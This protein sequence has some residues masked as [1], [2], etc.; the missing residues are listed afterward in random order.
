MTPDGRF[1]VIGGRLVVTTPPGVPED[2][3]ALDHPRVPEDFILKLEFR[4]TPNAD[5]GVYLR[6]PQLQCRDYRLAGPYKDLKSY[7][8]QDWNELVVTVQNGVARAT[9]N[10]ELLEADLKV[11]RPGPSAWRATAAR[12]STGASGSRD[13]PTVGTAR[14]LSVARLVACPARAEV[15]PMRVS[16][17]SL[18][19]AACWCSHPSW[20]WP[21]DTAAA[22]ASSAPG[23]GPPGD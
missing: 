3:A 16:I 7:K 20:S 12:W 8:P 14:P 23:A 2:P 22:S 18:S 4:A 21:P 13:C 1:A 6:G 17:L 9:C 10:G 19:V 5:S 15:T 11:P